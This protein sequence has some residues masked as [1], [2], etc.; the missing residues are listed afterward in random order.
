MRQQSS[1]TAEHAEVAER[2]RDGAIAISCR[3]AKKYSAS[4]LLK[5][6]TNRLI[7]LF[8]LSCRNIPLM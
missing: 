4:T 2:N 6:S 7:I 1:F 8:Q 3:E 5:S